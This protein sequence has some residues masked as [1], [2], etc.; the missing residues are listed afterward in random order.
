MVVKIPMVLRTTAKNADLKTWVDGR[1][2]PREEYF[3]DVDE[4]RQILHR[5]A[6][7]TNEAL[8]LNIASLLKEE[9]SLYQHTVDKQLESSKTEEWEQL[10]VAAAWLILVRHEAAVRNGTWPPTI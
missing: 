6:V 1:N 4:Y 3:Q 8:V 5:H 9:E 7:E 2:C 10:C